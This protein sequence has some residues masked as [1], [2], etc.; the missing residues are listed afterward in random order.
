MT[1]LLD[2]ER[3]TPETNWYMATL[4][5]EGSANF[6][7]VQHPSLAVNI[8][9]MLVRVERGRC[10]MCGLRRVRFRL[11][12]NTSNASEAVCAKCAGMRA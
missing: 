10:A 8:S 1:E 5:G 4:P 11:Q 12:A 9:V 3:I 6:T 7:L 2:G